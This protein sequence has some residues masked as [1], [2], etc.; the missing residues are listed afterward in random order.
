MG[1]FDEAIQKKIRDL[2]QEWELHVNPPPVVEKHAEASEDMALELAQEFHLDEQAQKAKSYRDVL[3]AD[4][5]RCYEEGTKVV[6]DA[7]GIP[8]RPTTTLHCGT[9]Q[10]W[11]QNLISAVL[12]L[13]NGRNST[14]L[15]NMV[16]CVLC[17]RVTRVTKASSS[18]QIHSTSYILIPG[19]RKNTSQAQPS[20]RR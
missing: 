12:T 16:I 19:T 3:A 2:L 14:Y 6:K 11:F 7:E 9:W 15:V 8:T 18:R 5:M 13:A 4:R 20:L 17:F 1:Y 10:T